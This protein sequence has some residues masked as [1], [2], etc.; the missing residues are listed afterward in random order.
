MC[1]GGVYTH[2]LVARTVSLRGVQISRT[3]IAQGVLQ[4]ACRISPCRFLCF[5]VSS[6]I[7]VVPARSLR[8]HVSV[9]TLFVEL[10]PTQKKRGSSALPHERQEFWLPGR[11]HALHTVVRDFRTGKLSHHLQVLTALEGQSA[12]TSKMLESQSTAAALEI[13]H[14]IE[15]KGVQ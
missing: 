7:L 10:Y 8:H 15:R 12:R 5:H 14:L 3:R 13:V 9:S 2:S 1:D 11:S 4:C 6:A